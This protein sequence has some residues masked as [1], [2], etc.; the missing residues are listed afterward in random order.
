MAPSDELSYL[1]DLVRQLNEK[2]VSLEQNA[3]VGVS[4]STPAEQLRMILVGPPGAGTQRPWRRH[5]PQG[6]EGVF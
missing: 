2:I 4:K 3:K 6:G 5:S 1:K